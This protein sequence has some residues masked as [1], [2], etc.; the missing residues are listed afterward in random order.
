MEIP[1]N[2]R[3]CLAKSKPC[4][5][6]EKIMNT[7]RYELV[8]RYLSNRILQAGYGLIT[9]AIPTY[10]RFLLAFCKLCQNLSPRIQIQNYLSSLRL[11]RLL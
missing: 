7:T 8:S 6:S 5:F 10:S 9:G 1:P 3:K 2:K 4:P 11:S